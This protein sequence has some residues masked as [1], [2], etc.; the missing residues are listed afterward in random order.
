MV[1][2][3]NRVIGVVAD[4]LSD[5]SHTE[6]N[7]LFRVGGNVSVDD[8]TG[9]RAN[10]I[11]HGLDKINEM[12]LLNRAINPLGALGKIL[13]SYMDEELPPEPRLA[14]IFSDDTIANRNGQR[15]ENRERIKTSLRNN[16]LVYQRGGIIASLTLAAQPILTLTEQIEQE[17]LSA[18]QREITGATQAVQNGDSAEAIRRAGVLLEAVYKAY[19][20]RHSQD[21]K[22]NETAAPLWQKL[23]AHLG[24]RPGEQNSAEW[25]DIYSSLHKIARNI[26]QL[27]NDYGSHGQTQA[28]HSAA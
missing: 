10:K 4:I 5:Y 1:E 7:S 3:P 27:R 12:W 15:R 23:S 28:Q 9:N 6:I 14:P 13:E 20:D 24:I 19:L 8:F 17:G 22:C 26:M 25:R 2:I 21:Y 18:V 16:A 11:M